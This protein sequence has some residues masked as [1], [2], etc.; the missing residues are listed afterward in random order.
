MP[1]LVN[2]LRML[3]ASD[4][5]VEVAV[6]ETGEHI[7][8][9][10]GE[11]HLE[12]CLRDLKDRYAKI[13]VQ[14]SAPIV[15][16]RETIAAADGKAATDYSVEVFSP[17]KSCRLKM[18]CF[19]LSDELASFIEHHAKEMRSRVDQ[20]AEQLSDDFGH[21]LQKRLLQDDSSLKLDR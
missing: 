7:I 15:P 5:A 6:Q 19:P 14:A 10:A 12:R 9:T 20:A 17:N 4:P 18:R 3:N 2:G 16:F 1:E 13:D 8:S 11:L 21:E